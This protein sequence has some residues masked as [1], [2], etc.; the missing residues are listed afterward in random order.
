MRGKGINYDTGSHIADGWTRT[1]FASSSVKRDMQTIRD[2]LHCTAVRISGSIPER[3]TIAAEHAAEAGLEV[4]FSPFPCDLTT[5]EMLSLFVECAT[6]AEV[7]RRNGAKV[8]L[9]TG[10]E[11]SIFGRGFLPGDD[12]FSRTALF[13]AR[14]PALPGLLAAV[15]AQLNVFL[16]EVVNAVRAKFGGK[17][18]YAS[19]PFERVDWTRFDYVA[20]DAYRAAHNAPTYLEEIRGL[21]RHGLPVVVTEFGCCT[22]RGAADRGG[23]GFL[24][25]DRN[26]ERWRLDGDYQRDEQEQ[27]RYLRE[28]LEVFEQA[29]VDT[30]FWFTFAGY[31]HPYD[32][33]PR[34]DIDMASYGVVKVKSDM[35]LEPKASFHALAAE[36]GKDKAQ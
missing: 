22:Y 3:L 10:G 8:I 17:L 6:H 27:V 36:Y 21:R 30:A 29:N 26:R 12:F 7:L 31:R 20:A 25:I 33:D 13:T 2:E 35:S 1:I 14:G 15:P 11:L 24:I 18:T 28:L 23:R 34:Y 5:D 4:W 32:P 9:V 16:G 19:L